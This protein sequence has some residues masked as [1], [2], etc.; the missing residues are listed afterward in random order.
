MKGIDVTD[1]NKT[2]LLI[3]EAHSASETVF[4]KPPGYK[5]SNVKKKGGG[6]QLEAKVV[7]KNKISKG[8]KVSLRIPTQFMKTLRSSQQQ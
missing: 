6:V 4:P 1:Q 3:C 2:Y 8:K 5:I 7:Q